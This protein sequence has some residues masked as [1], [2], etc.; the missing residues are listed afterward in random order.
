MFRVVSSPIIRS[1]YTC[2]YSIWHLS[3]RNCYMMLPWMSWNSLQFQL[4]HDSD[5]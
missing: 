3:N 1:T 4:L 5:R 2:I